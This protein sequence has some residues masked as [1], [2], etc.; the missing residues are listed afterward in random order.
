[1]TILISGDVPGQT[2]EGYEETIRVLGEA[3]RKAPGFIAHMGHPIPGGWRVIE[4]WES[5]RAASDWFAKAVRPNL[6]PN[7]KPA[8]K[9]TELH[10]FIRA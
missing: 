3:M 2:K 6:P 7:I 9:V 4:V 1:M 8:R 10:T 5:A